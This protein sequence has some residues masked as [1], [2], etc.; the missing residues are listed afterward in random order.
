MISLIVEQYRR[1]H[2]IRGGAGA[3]LAIGMRYK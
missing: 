1:R 3:D 2:G